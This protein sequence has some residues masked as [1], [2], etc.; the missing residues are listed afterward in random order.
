MAIPAALAR[1]MAVLLMKA[2]R[3]KETVPGINVEDLIR[4]ALSLKGPHAVV[5]GMDSVKVV[6]SNLDILRN[7]KEMSPEEMRMMAD[8]LIPFYKSEN[9]PWMQEGYKDGL[10]G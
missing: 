3:P 1:G 8:R 2:V 5:V 4:Y 7:F 9:L 10:W 6:K